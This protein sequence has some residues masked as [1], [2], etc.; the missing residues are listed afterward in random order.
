MTMNKNTKLLF[1]H[2]VL[3]DVYFYGAIIVPFFVSKSYDISTALTLAAI[4]MAVSILV[5]LPTGIIADR[6]GHK[7]SIIFG[8][9]LTGLA[10]LG[11]IAFDGIYLDGLWIITLAIGSALV[12]GSDI[13]LLRATSNDF[14][15]DN[16]SFDYLKSV[17]LLLSF[18]SA[19]FIVK[20]LSFDAAIGLS[21]LLAFLS[22]VPLFF[23]YQIM[24]SRAADTYVSFRKQ[25]GDLPA[26]LRNVDGG[27]PLLTFGGLVAGVLFSV[28]EIVSSLSPLYQ[29]D[30]SLIGIVAG[31]AMGARIIGT[32]VEKR[33]LI[34]SRVLLL[35]FSAVIMA[36]SVVSLSVYAGM[37]LLVVSSALAQMLFYKLSYRLSSQAPQAH[38]ASIV[39]GLTLTG[40]LS[41]G[42]MI[43]ISGILAGNGYFHLTFLIVGLLLVGIGQP[44]LRNIAHSELAKQLETHQSNAPDRNIP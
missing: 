10:L 26:S 41:S 34:S 13:A 3:Y 30:I 31:L 15:R 6:Y 36:T 4:Y 8:V 33:M 17:M 23:I 28:K 2:K 37:A 22:I 9:F 16:R 43:F 24:S 18:G 38:V 11:F 21:S 39:S 1:L 29:V 27:F 5:E 25:V 44:L 42:G 35:W 12:S 40:R 20:Y 14:E 32:Y 7:L 19:G